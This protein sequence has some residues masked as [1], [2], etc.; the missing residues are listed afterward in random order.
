MKMVHSAGIS[1]NNAEQ[2]H[3]VK[4]EAPDASGSYFSQVPNFRPGDSAS[5]EEEFGRFASSQ[6]ITPGSCDGHDNC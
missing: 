5:F 1:A 4:L 3:I 2:A 6:N